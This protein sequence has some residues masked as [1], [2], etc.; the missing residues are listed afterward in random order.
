MTTDVKDVVLAKL[1]DHVPD[2]VDRSNIDVYSTLKEMKLDSLA[3]LQII[4]E[5]EEHFSITLEESELSH[6]AT[7][8]DLISA[9]DKTRKNV[10]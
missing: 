7:I 8:A 6:L 2:R 3:V 1:A 9:I 4:Y 5:L 10:A